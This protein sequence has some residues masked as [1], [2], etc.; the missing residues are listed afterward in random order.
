METETT[1]KNNTVEYL[2]RCRRLEHLQRYNCSR[3]SFPQ[4]VLQHVGHGAVILNTILTSPEAIKKLSAKTMVACYGGW[5]NHD[6]EEQDTS[7]IPQPVKVAMLENDPNIKEVLDAT[8]NTVFDKYTL[9]GLEEK[10][11][12]KIYTEWSYS[13]ID[14]TEV[15]GME[16]TVAN[17]IKFVD[18]FELCLYALEQTVFGSDG[19]LGYQRILDARLP[20][21]WGISDK[22]ELEICSTLYTELCDLCENKSRVQLLETCGTSGDYLEVM[23]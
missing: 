22:T 7:D 4:S 9:R 23:K 15:L 21:L 14:R 20:Y 18:T 3:R 6:M 19:D 8:I 17:I 5:I 10:H 16:A 2:V 11:R 1:L 12:K 13:R